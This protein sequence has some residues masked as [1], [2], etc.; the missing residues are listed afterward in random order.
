MR[1]QFGLISIY[2]LRKNLLLPSPVHKTSM[3]LHTVTSQKALIVAAT[4]MRVSDL[5]D[6]PLV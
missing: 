5:S 1:Q 6:S 4:A 2:R 3:K